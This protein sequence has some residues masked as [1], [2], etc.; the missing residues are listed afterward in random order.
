MNILCITEWVAS[1]VI[2][3][4]T[5]SLIT[6]FLF[7]FLLWWAGP[8]WFESRSSAGM[9]TIKVKISEIETTYIIEMNKLKVVILK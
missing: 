6:L 5:S 8:L 7:L 4:A 3:T 2:V 1:K 9:E